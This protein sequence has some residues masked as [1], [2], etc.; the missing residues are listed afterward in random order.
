M[1]FLANSKIAASA[2]RLAPLV[3]SVKAFKASIGTVVWPMTLSLYA[4][5]AVTYG[6]MIALVAASSGVVI[7]TDRYR[8][9][10][11]ATS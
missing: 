6:S 8:P 10:L 5:S 7:T 1:L 4:A 9:V 3:S 11:L 2:C